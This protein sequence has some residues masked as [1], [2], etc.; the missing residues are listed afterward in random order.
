MEVW[1]DGTIRRGE[2]LG[3]SRRLEPL[4]AA[5]ALAHRLVGV[6]G[7]IV[8][9]AVLPMF[10]TGPHLALSRAVALELIRA[11]HPGRVLAAFQQLTEACLR[12]LRLPPRLDADVPQMPIMIRDAPERL[13][14]PIARRQHRIA[15]PRIPGPRP[16]GAQVMGLRLSELLAP[17]PDGFVGD[18]DA[19]FEQEPCTSR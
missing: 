13:A 1:R 7:A 8:P 17:L 3:V 16:L 2:T 11:E 10:H 18:V 14:C 5:F 19:A 9:R 15:M 4:H 6:S 12:A